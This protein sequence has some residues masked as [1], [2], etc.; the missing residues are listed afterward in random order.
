MCIY[1]HLPLIPSHFPFRFC[2][3]LNGNHAPLHPLQKD[4]TFRDHV[5]RVLL[6]DTE[7]PARFVNS[8]LRTIRF[9]RPVTVAFV[10]EPTLLRRQMVLQ[11]SF[12]Q[13]TCVMGAS[14]ENLLPLPDDTTTMEA[15]PGRTDVW[16][17]VHA[18]ELFFETSPI[19]KQTVQRCEAI[20]LESLTQAT[21]DSSSDTAP[22]TAAA[23]IGAATHSSTH[24]GPTPVNP[25]VAIASVNANLALNT[26]TSK[27]KER[28]YGCLIVRG[29]R[30]V[31]ARSLTGEWPGLRI[32]HGPK[33]EGETASQAALRVTSNM[34]EVEESEFKI[35]NALAPAMYYL[36]IIS[37]ASSAIPLAVN[38]V[39]VFVAQATSPPPPGPLEDADV[40]DDSDLYDWYTFPRAMARVSPAERDVLCVLALA[41]AGAARVG[42]VQPRWGGVFGQELQVNLKYS[43]EDLYDVPADLLAARLV[44]ASVGGLD[45]PRTGEDVP[46]AEADAGR[47]GDRMTDEAEVT[48]FREQ[49]SNAPPPSEVQPLPVTILSGFLGAGKTTLLQHILTNRQGLKVYRYVGEA[50]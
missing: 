44:E 29:N 20:D 5:E 11:A 42:L 50:S 26:E 17:S 40:E 23:C 41:L 4:K 14:L 37:G 32:P 47:D 25:L 15:A 12:S 27:V 28:L 6:F 36:P 34:I 3:C 31:L 16:E 43:A 1:T 18:A 8:R 9:D 19:T 49:L 22:A 48:R 24:H 21:H 46:R 38:V 10:D 35:I 39:T 7:L 30:C 2:V 45:L 33:L 13:L